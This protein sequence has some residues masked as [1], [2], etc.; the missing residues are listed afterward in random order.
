[1]REEDGGITAT[2][3]FCS[4]K[5]RFAPGEFALDVIPALV[6]GIHTSTKGWSKLMD[7]SLGQAPG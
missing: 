4:R 5:Y 2:C 7:A 1:M 6:A 3:E